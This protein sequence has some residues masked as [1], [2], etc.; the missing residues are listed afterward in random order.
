MKKYWVTIRHV[1]YASV[2]VEADDEDTLTEVV[3]EL[4][5]EYLPWET[6]AWEIVDWEPAEE[7]E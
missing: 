1:Q 2:F 6:Q 5:D 4:P 3:S 7:N